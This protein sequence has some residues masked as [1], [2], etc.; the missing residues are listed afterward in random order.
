MPNVDTQ[1]LPGMYAYAKVT[2]ERRV[3]ALPMDAL[4]P[5]G[6]QTFFWRYDRG[7]ARRTEIQTGISDNKWTEVTNYRDVSSDQREEHTDQTP[8]TPI[9]GYQQVLWH[10]RISRRERL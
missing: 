7:H 8:W 1:I 6:D 10:W 3:L 2:I 4:V 5:K 9:E